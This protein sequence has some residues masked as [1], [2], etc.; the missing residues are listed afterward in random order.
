M[1]S[2]TLSQVRIRSFEKLQ[3]IW[4]IW[5]NLNWFSFVMVVWFQAQV[6]LLPQLLQKMTL[7]SKVFKS[8]TKIVL[9][10]VGLAVNR[11]SRIMYPMVAEKFSIPT[12]K[13]K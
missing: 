11:S 3:C 8:D 7:A 5:K 12:T 10:S 6:L 13:T 4:E 1:G 9:I 2:R